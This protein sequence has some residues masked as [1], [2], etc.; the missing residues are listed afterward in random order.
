MSRHLF[1]IIALVLA[2]GLQSQV[3]R[4]QDS[5]WGT[6][7]W[8]FG[9]QDPRLTATGI[10]VGL[11]TEG[12]YV[13]MRH[14]IWYNKGTATAYTGRPITVLGAYT[15]TT[16]ACAALFPIVGTI[17]MNRPLTPREVY[18]GMAD[19]VV[20]FIGGWFVDATLPHTAWYDGTPVPVVRHR[21]R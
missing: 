5:T 3:V 20:P 18:R 16:G 2:L 7:G 17:W 9:N 13:A 10:A 4:A 15:L 6:W 21:H 11:G 8:L 14:K 12:I 19:C 1:R